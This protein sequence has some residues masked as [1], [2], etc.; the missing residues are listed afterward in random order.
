MERI[1]IE[2]NSK[3]KT[4]M[5]LKFL[6]ELNIPYSS[7]NNPSPSGDRWFSDPEN[8]NILEKGIADEKAGRVSRIKDVNNLWESIL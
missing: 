2:L 5:L 1:T 4:Q 3:K 7:E 8:V 6:E